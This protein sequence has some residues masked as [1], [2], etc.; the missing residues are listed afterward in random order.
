MAQTEAEAAS[1]EATTE[2]AIK[3]AE[4]T[5]SESIRTTLPNDVA[6]V[7]TKRAFSPGAM[8][9]LLRDTYYL[10]PIGI[11]RGGWIG[12][13]GGGQ[14]GTEMRRPQGALYKFP[15]SW[16]FAALQRA[17]STGL[18]THVGDGTFTTSE[19]GA[20]V[21]SMVDVCPDCGEQR[22]PMIQ[23]SYHVGNPNSAGH[24]ENHRLVTKCPE[25]GGD[26]YSDRSGGISYSAFE[27]EGEYAESVFETF[28]DR[29]D[30]RVFGDEKSI[31][32][33]AAERVPETNADAI[34]SLLEDVVANQTIPTPRDIFGTQ[35]EDL[36][37]RPVIPV[38]SSS[39]SLF[40]FSGTDDALAVSRCD[41]KGEVH[42]TVEDGR[43][44]VNMSYEVAVKQGAKEAIKNDTTEASWEGDHWTIHPRG[45]CHAVC[46]LAGFEK[47]YG[48]WTVTA[49][50]SAAALC[51][52]P[53]VGITEDGDLIEADTSG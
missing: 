30:V 15:R 44:R 33:A 42:F 51:S 47:Y 41:E 13:F 52:V 50:P 1:E 36:Y 37:E 16:R 22:E 49:T 46:V 35:T 26:G 6:A 34:E 29:D 32:E 38:S 17:L 2:Q 9:K 23:S 19:R 24:I 43:L 4:A 14:P 8:R 12:A 45:L 3:G 7:L 20:A 48:R 39:G 31:D 53:L 21:L 25:C 10:G 5:D 11:G 27:R 28:A 40:R 18:I